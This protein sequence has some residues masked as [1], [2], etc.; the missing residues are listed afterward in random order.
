MKNSS[1]IVK[2]IPFSDYLDSFKKT[3]RSVF[4]E[5]DNLVKFTDE[6]GFPPLVLQDIIGTH[7]LGVCDG[8]L[9]N[10]KII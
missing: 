1:E 10:D 8:S 6:R 2:Q 7:A 3:L 5:K 4:Y 9:R